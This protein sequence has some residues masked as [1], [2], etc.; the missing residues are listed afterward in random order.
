[1]QKEKNANVAYGAGSEFTLTVIKHAPS[2]ALYEHILKQ[3]QAVLL[4]REGKP[5]M[6][7]TLRNQISGA[8]AGVTVCSTGKTKKRQWRGSVV[9]QLQSLLACTKGSKSLSR[10]SASGQQVGHMAQTV[11]IRCMHR[12]LTS[13]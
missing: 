6:M 4:A 1:M 13:H 2:I 12:V 5:L 9:G 11:S 8:D 7:W 3:F 10:C